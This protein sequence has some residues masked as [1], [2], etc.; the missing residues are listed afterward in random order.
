MLLGT[1]GNKNAKTKNR[2]IRSHN[3]ILN[4]RKKIFD[5]TSLIQFFVYLYMNTLANK[6]HTHRK[7]HTQKS[8]LNRPILL[9]CENISPPVTNSNTMYKFELSWKS[10]QQFTHPVALWYSCF[11]L[12]AKISFL[13]TRIYVHKLFVQELKLE[14][15][16]IILVFNTKHVHHF[17]YWCW[18]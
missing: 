11:P 6:I 13:I 18:L 17:I 3:N 5:F 2:A 8:Y 16:L 10:K 12:Q 4:W 15:D 9:K 7:I 14:H 1:L